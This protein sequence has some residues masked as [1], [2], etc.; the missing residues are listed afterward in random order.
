MQQNC[1]ALHLF[2]L[3]VVSYWL[4]ALAFHLVALFQV[5][6]LHVWKWRPAPAILTT[7]ELRAAIGTVIINQF[8]VTLPLAVMFRHDIACTSEQSSVVV[9]LMYLAVMLLAEEV[10]FYYIHRVLHEPKFYFAIHRLHHHYIH[11]VA[12]TALAT[13]PLE[14]LLLNVL[15]IVASAHYLH[16]PANV[17]QLWTVLATVN[18]VLAHCGYRTLDATGFHDLHHKYIR[19]NFGFLGLMD[20]LHG[21]SL[22]TWH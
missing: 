18:A 12:L 3:H 17:V 13:H 7:E 15:P 14:H 8:G 5:S 9:M 21:T 16:V 20:Y 10:M 1:D 19:G 6:T 4:F 2:Y 11:P 22:V